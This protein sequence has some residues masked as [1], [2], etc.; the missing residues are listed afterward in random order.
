MSETSDLKHRLETTA[1]AIEALDAAE[2][3]GRLGADEH[4]RQRAER[5][6]EAGRLFVRLRRAQRESR[7]HRP[8]PV[9]ETTGPGRRRLRRPMTMAAAAV[10]L[11]VAGVAG[12]VTVG[13]WLGG[14]P[15]VSA[16]AAVSPPAPGQTPSAQMTETAL[17]ALAQTAPREDAPI[18]TLLEFAHGALDHR[19]LDEARRVYGQV[20][21][22]DPRNVEAITHQGAVLF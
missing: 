21:A 8:E 11:L 17:Q 16:P 2:A 13:R 6:R 4:A 19:R 9:V 15:G 20:L 12:G 22:R 7:E 1:A 10:A 18:P 3:A 5:E 14:A